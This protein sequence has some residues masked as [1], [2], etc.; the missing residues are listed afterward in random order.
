MLNLEKCKRILQKDSKKN[1]SDEEVKQIRDL[2]FKIG[3]L[4]NQIFKTSKPS[5]HGKCNTLH[6]GIN[7]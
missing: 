2:L 1:Y 5:Q 6:K 4:D 3:N 7:R